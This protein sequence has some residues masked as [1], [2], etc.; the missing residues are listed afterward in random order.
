VLDSLADKIGE[1][2][3]VLNELFPKLKIV[4]LSKPRRWEKGGNWLKMALNSASS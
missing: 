4:D 1:A 2:D 3:V